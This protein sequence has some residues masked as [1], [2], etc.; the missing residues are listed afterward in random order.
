MDSENGGSKCLQELGSYH[1]NVTLETAR[2]L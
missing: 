2:F 1:K